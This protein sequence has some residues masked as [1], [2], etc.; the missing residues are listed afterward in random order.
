MDTL[1]IYQAMPD[2]VAMIF[3]EGSEFDKCRDRD[4][5]NY[6]QT[7]TEHTPGQWQT[8]KKGCIKKEGF[9]EGIPVWKNFMFHFWGNPV[10]PLGYNWTVSPEDYARGGTGN[11]YLGERYPPGSTSR[12]R[13]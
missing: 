6:L 5:T 11:N 10:S 7:E 13:R 12:S 1:M 9:D 8:G 4:E 3:W 2:R